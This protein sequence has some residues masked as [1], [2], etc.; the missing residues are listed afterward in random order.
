[1]LVLFCWPDGLVLLLFLALNPRVLRCLPFFLIIL[2]SSTSPS[3]S[4]FYLSFCIPSS[5]FCSSPLP[6]LPLPP[7]SSPF[8]ILTPYPF[9]SSPPS[10]L[11]T[12]PPSTHPPSTP[13]P[14]HPLIL[15]LILLFLHSILFVSYQHY[16]SWLHKH[17]E[18]SSILFSTG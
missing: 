14:F 15:L 17:C 8:Y 10:F 5:P 3:V 6:P 7:S 11:P 4:T 12:P 13:P 16:S 18:S 9:L 1:M 2:D